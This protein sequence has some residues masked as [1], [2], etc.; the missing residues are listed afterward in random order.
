MTVALPT[1]PPKKRGPTSKVALASS[2]HWGQSYL[3]GMLHDVWGP[4]RLSPLGSKG[5]QP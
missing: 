4:L 5:H 3:Q 2:S 1:P